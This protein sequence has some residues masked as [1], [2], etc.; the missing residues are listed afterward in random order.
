MIIKKV[1]HMLRQKKYTI[2][3]Q[4][5]SYNVYYILIFKIVS[6]H[7]YHKFNDYNI[8]LILLLLF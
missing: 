7:L 4:S 1:L 8:I 6:I 5:L 2:L 3:C